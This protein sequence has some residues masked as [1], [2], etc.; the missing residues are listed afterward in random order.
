MDK[1]VMCSVADPDP[2]CGVFF[3]PGSGIWIGDDKKD[4]GSGTNIPV[5]IFEN[6]S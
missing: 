3:T 5:L 4:P 2:G 1:N 6:L